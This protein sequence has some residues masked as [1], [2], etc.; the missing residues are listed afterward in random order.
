MGKLGGVAEGVGQPELG[1]LGAELGL[2]EALA[3]EELTDEGLARGNIAVHF[4]PRATY[5]RLIFKKR[6]FKRRPW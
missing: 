2:E 1:A 4:D 5:K 3:E 6:K